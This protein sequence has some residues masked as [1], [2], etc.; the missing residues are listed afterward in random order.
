MKSKGK[1]NYALLQR[2]LYQVLVCA[3]YIKD[4][5]MEKKQVYGGLSYLKYDSL[6]Q[7]MPLQNRS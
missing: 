4:N 7:D 6:V 1:Q 2:G 5:S 3:E